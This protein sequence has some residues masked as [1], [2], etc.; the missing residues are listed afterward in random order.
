[1]P[2]T[3]ALGERRSF[4]RF[5]FHTEALFHWKSADGADRSGNGT[6]RDVSLHG[7]FITSDACP[8]EGMV[9][10]VRL[11]LS[12]LHKL[13]HMELRG[14]VLRAE[15]ID[16]EATYGFALHADKHLSIINLERTGE[17]DAAPEAPLPMSASASVQH[18]RRSGLLSGRPLLRCSPDAN[19][20]SF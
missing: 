15:S 17:S 16:A 14:R 12:G 19:N 20:N 1:M 9:V 10:T 3:A 13:R 5:G 8:Q 7:V 18:S 11:A 4:I 2:S 6:T